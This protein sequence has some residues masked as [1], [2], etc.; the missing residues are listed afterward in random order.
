M[1][2]QTSIDMRQRLQIFNEKRERENKQTLQIGIGINSDSVI[3][4]NIGSSK[5]M[6]FTAI[7]D[8][9][10]LGSRLEGASKQ[11][12]CDI[13]ISDSTYAPNAHL[14][15]A[16]ELDF[17]KVKGKT[18][19]VSVYELVALRDGPLSRPLSDKKAAVIEHY[20]KAR[21]HYLKREFAMAMGKFA[22]ALEIDSHDK[23]SSLHLQRCQYWLQ[24]SP[25]DDWDG[26]W[27]MKE[28]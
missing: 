13:V 11:Y 15:W 14:V 1:A 27:E 26:S 12:G 17:I 9:V 5:R 6:E 19:P 28:K 18:K 20:D 2:I 21:Q 25:P 22:Q 8:G 4:G 24:N 7:G 23:A 10:N 16:R 3:S